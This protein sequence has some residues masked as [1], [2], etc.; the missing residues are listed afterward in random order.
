MM[1]HC[2]PAA[3][4]NNTRCPECQTAFRLDEDVSRWTLAQMSAVSK[5]CPFC[6]KYSIVLEYRALSDE[7][8]PERK[9]PRR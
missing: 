9:K 1:I 2:E 5:R 8:V 3:G 7:G 4:P 6:G